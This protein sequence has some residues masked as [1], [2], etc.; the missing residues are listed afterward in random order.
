MVVSRQEYWSGVP[1]PPPGDLPHPGIKPKSP[2]LQVDCWIKPK[3]PAFPGGPL[4]HLG[5]S[6]C[7]IYRSTYKLRGVC[8]WKECVCVEK[9][10]EKD[11]DTEYGLI[12][13]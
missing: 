2:A 5:N 9:G 13:L 12:S 4:S 6:V 10:K 1:F 11:I 7:Y 8:V 3:S